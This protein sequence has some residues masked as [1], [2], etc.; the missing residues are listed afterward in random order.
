[1]MNQLPKFCNLFGSLCIN[2]VSAFCFGS[3]PAYH[4]TSS[5]PD[6]FHEVFSCSVVSDSLWPHGLHQARLHCSSTSPRACS[7]P[8]P[9]SQWCH[10]TISSSVVPFSLCLQSFS[11]SGFFQMSQFFAS[12]GWS[13]GVSASTSV[14]SVNIQAW[15]PLGLTGLISL[16]SKELSRV[17][18]NTIVQNISCSAL[19]LLYGPALTS[20]HDH[21][22]TILT[23]YRVSGEILRASQV[24]LL[25]KNSYA[26]AGHIRDADWIPGLGRSPGGGRGNL[27]QYSFL[28]NPMDRGALLALAHG[29]AQ[30]RTRLKWLHMHMCTE[31][32]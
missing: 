6:N 16:K 5:V 32:S 19:S 31:S 12:D 13:I 21:V 28:E 7:N 18:S 2:S 26:E 30:S 17:F 9:L 8:Y 29:V 27:L 14:L 24:V 1:M 22:S 4:T 20:I 10:P 23:C 3:H 25:V 11:A 15:F